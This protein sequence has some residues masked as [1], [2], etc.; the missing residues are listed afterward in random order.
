M[1][2]LVR[3]EPVVHDD[4][5]W[6]ISFWVEITGIPLHLW[7][8]KNLRRIGSKL[9]HI[10]TVDLSAGRLLLDIDTRKPLLFSH[11]VA[12][13]KGEEVTIK[14]HYEKL[15]KHCSTCGLLTHENAYCP[16]KAGVSARVQLP[17]DD[18]SRQPLLK[19][20][21]QIDKKP[22]VA[23]NKLLQVTKPYDKKQYNDYGNQN[24]WRDRQEGGF[25]SDARRTQYVTDRRDDKNVRHGGY[26]EAHGR[27]GDK[28][29]WQNGHTDRKAS[30]PTRYGTRYAPY[31]TKNHQSWRAKEHIQA[32]E[33]VKRTESYALDVQPATSEKSSN[34]KTSEVKRQEGN[35]SVGKKIASKIVTP[36]RGDQDV[37]VTKRH[38]EVIRPISFSPKEKEML[39][40]DQMIGA[41]TGMEIIGTMI[42]C[43]RR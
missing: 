7:T 6:I 31:H 38:R 1:F 30:H 22:F 41:L 5:P 42:Q 35:E 2:V 27:Y 3:W 4:Y 25:I 10:D 28:G 20:H 37:N 8:I 15:F 11:K 24:A 21:K 16:Q 19:D 18:E 29:S 32:R 23:S 17:L 40:E 36:V 14:M 34:V 33:G 12:S 26:H 9:G 13:P 39:D 43:K